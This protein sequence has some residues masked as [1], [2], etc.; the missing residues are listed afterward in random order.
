MNADEKPKGFERLA[1]QSRSDARMRRDD[2]A[3]TSEQQQA[4]LSELR[5][6]RITYRVAGR[7]LSWKK[8]AELIGLPESTLSEVAKGTYKGDVQKCFRLID[9]FLADER[10]RRGRFD[11]RSFA[12]TSL[13]RQI[14]GVIRNGVKNNSMPVVIGA[15]GSGKSIHA[16]AYAADR[17]GVILVRVDQAHGDARGVTLLL[18]QAISGLRNMLDKPF[19]KR[20]ASVKGYLA[21]HRNTVI[22]VD[23]AQKLDRDGLEMLRDL[24]DSS[25]PDGRRNVP[26]VFFADRDFYKL[27]LKS[28]AGQRSPI[29][30]Q[31][32]RRMYPIFDVEKDGANEDGCVFTVQDV[33][34]V[35]RNDR[36]RIVSAAGIKWITRL[37]NTPG[38]GLIGFAMAVVRMACDLAHGETVDVEDLG[39]ALKLALGPDVAEEI[40]EVADGELLRK[41]AG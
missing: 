6:H 17:D 10:L 13:T 8:V 28:R 26:I 34:A 14:W 7:P 38:Y 36:L 25:D 23:E 16:R 9:Q 37:A 39:E 11:D 27:I 35:L 4:L 12:T 41:A 19:R 18:C 5:D 1:A 22:V 15:P 33:V 31:L 29:A 24:H 21:K 20:V 32:S 3:Y 40:D 2:E 30:P